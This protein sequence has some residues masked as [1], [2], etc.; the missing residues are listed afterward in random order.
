MGS[1]GDR[2]RREREARGITLDDVA[3]TTKIRAGLLKALEDERFD[4][5]PGGIFNKGFV[6]AYARHLGI[7]EEQAVNDYLI[8]SGEAPRR[9]GEAAGAR[10]EI[11]EPRIQLVHE[12][13]EEEPASSGLLRY[14]A[15]LLILVAVGVI[16]WFYYNHERQ[17]EVGT[18]PPR[19]VAS[20]SAASEPPKEVPAP[21]AQQGSATS[22]NSTTTPQAKPGES[23]GPSAAPTAAAPAA[24]GFTV[25][26]RADED[27]WMKIDADGKT[28][29]VT[30]PSGSVKQ[31]TAKDKVTVRV[32]NIGALNVSFNGNK[33]PSQGEYG[34]VRTLK[35]GPMG[36]EPLKPATPP[37]SA[38]PAPA[39]PEG[40]PQ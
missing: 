40:N 16:A 6:R 18:E 4:Q 17:A 28:E 30:L 15:G 39:Q 34:E 29:E 36:L 38:A 24:G 9:T 26:L 21:S 33:L 35:F 25:T 2:L 13:K 5:L 19:A 8:A 37:A 3:L 10:G 22:T 12:E 31:I 23:P 20:S 32:G 7:D 27:C 1:F 11:P 14:V